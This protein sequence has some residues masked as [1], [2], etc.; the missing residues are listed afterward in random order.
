[1]KVL[2]LVAL[3]LLL[4]C[5]PTIAEGEVEYKNV[6]IEVNGERI[7]LLDAEE[8]QQKSI[9]VDGTVY[10]P[11]EC[12]IKAL[13]GE[14]TY[15]AASNQITMMLAPAASSHSAT[16]AVSYSDADI[17]AIL[18]KGRW[19]NATAQ[20]T[21]FLDF[22]SDYTGMITG[23]LPC[24]WAVSEVAVSLYFTSQGK[25]WHSEYVFTVSGSTFQLVRGEQ[26]FTL[27]DST[28][29]RI[30][31][32][33]TWHVPGDDSAELILKADATCQIKLSG[34]TYQGT[35]AMDAAHVYLTQN[36]STISGAYNGTSI[37]LNIG[38]KNFT[39]TR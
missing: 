27:N 33:G 13:G 17:T 10:V 3:M 25:G 8:E 32:I 14:I 24:T 9:I 11:V 12:F 26:A 7:I 36:G 28:D 4:G 34:L 37:G 19:I 20:G 2:S 6:K 29:S 30:D 16:N 18:T 39:F 15:D 31:L 22:S 35:W 23:M 21:S 5:V 38:G 1:M